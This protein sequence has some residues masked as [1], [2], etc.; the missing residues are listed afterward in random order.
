MDRQAH[1]SPEYILYGFACQGKRPIKNYFSFSRHFGTE[2]HYNE[3]FF[4]FKGRFLCAQCKSYTDPC[5]RCREACLFG[6]R[7]LFSPGPKKWG[8]KVS[9]ESGVD[10]MDS[11]AGKDGAPEG[12]AAAA[13]G[14]RG[15]VLALEVG[16]VQGA[17]RGR[18]GD[19]RM[20]MVPEQAARASCAT[21]RKTRR[22]TTL[23]A[24]H[25]QN[26]APRPP[27][28]AGWEE[29][30]GEGGTLVPS[31]TITES[32]LR[33]PQRAVTEKE[34][35]R[36]KCA[37]RASLPGRRVRACRARGL[38]RSCRAAGLC[39]AHLQTPSPG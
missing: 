31:E 30:E 18:D 36:C 22:R 10:E 37:R 28:V 27:A 23:A 34:S 6:N 21:R 4:H 35:R 3:D 26:G 24:R 20:V 39:R 33:V 12:G 2:N 11:M 38:A 14:P 16:R 1:F 32:G 8:R 25:D 5:V 29:E 13:S 15:E 9:R 19:G 17:G 7:C